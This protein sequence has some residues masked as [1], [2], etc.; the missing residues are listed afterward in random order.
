M[1]TTVQSIAARGSQG[2]GHGTAGAG[3]SLFPDRGG[4]WQ[5]RAP[6]G[7]E[8]PEANYSNPVHNGASLFAQAAAAQS[9]NFEGLG[10]QR[11]APQVSANAATAASTAAGA[12]AGAASNSRG[13]QT[14]VPAAVGPSGVNGS[15]GN[16]AGMERRGPVEF[17]HAISYVNKIKVSPIM[18]IFL[19]LSTPFVYKWG[20]PL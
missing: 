10:P 3:Q 8:S 14:P 18:A 6:Y 20:A 19:S 16:Q 7:V 11:S 4:Q 9:G 5:Q 2:D 13:P 17:N 1:G 15:A 12:G